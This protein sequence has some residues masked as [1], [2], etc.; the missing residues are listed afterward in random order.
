MS[1][2]GNIATLRQIPKAR[3]YQ[4]SER[5]RMKIT[6][7]SLT[8]LISTATLALTSAF[9]ADAAV[10]VTEKFVVVIAE[11]CPEGD[12]ACNNVTYTGVNRSTGESVTLKGQAWVR[13]CADNVTPC[14]HIGWLFKNGEYT[15]RVRETPPLLEVERNGKTVLEQQAVWTDY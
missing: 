10:M 12:V 4:T 1:G 14:Q 8:G 6:N 7:R 9:H 3:S 2:E 11:R 13:M 5:L 15:Y